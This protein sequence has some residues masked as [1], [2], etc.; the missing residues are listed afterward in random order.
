MGIA[1]QR[2]RSRPYQRPSS[3]TISD[4]LAPKILSTLANHQRQVGTLN[5]V[6][7]LTPPKILQTKQNKPNPLL[8]FLS[9]FPSPFRTIETGREKAVPIG[10]G[11]FHESRKILIP[12]ILRTTSLESSFYNPQSPANHRFERI[13]NPRGEGVPYRRRPLG[14]TGSGARAAT[15]VCSA[16]QVRVQLRSTFI[17]VV[18][19]S[20]GSTWRKPS[21]SGGN[22]VPRNST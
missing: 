7:P 1:R 15:H 17:S 14:R 13:G 21:V 10:G 19:P 16:P 3:P 18:P 5:P 4:R 22:T 2:D 11:L 12:D 20:E 8:F 9:C 6:N